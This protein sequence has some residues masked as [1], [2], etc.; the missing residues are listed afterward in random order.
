M[1]AWLILNERSV[2]P[3]T[4]GS[5]LVQRIFIL[6]QPKARLY[7]LAIYILSLNRP[8]LPLPWYSF[9][10]ERLNGHHHHSCLL[11]EF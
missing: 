11:P 3:I 8:S 7:F 10:L 5:A 1:S 9:V 6:R 2:V 4:T